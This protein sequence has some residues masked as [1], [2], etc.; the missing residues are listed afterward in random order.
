MQDVIY[1]QDSTDEFIEVP[2]PEDEKI[3]PLNT[4]LR[5]PKTAAMPGM[6][7][8]RSNPRENINRPT[9]WLDLS[10]LHRSDADV[11]HRLRIKADGKFLTQEAQQPGTRARAF[12][13]PFNTMGVP[14]NTRPGVKPGELFAGGDP[15][16]NE[17]WL[18]PGIHTVLLREHNRLSDILRQ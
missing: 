6:G 10:S 1:S 9:T 18:L 17:D 7:T 13:L 5:V 3:F 2:M 15:R 4:T 11:A 16:T 8:S 12:Y 14:T